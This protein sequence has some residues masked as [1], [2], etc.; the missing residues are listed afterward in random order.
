LFAFVADHEFQLSAQEAANLVDLIDGHLRPH[1]RA[2]AHV[3]GSA[4]Q[5]KDEADANRLSGCLHLRGHGKRRESQC[6]ENGGAFHGNTLRV[7]NI[8]LHFTTPRCKRAAAVRRK[9]SRPAIK[10]SN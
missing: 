1:T 4:R 5:R 9:H 2:V 7:C 8:T 3:G 6:D 10:R